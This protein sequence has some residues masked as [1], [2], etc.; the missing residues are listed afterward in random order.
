[1]LTSGRLEA[2]IAAE[3]ERAPTEP[4]LWW[5]GEWWSRGALYE[6]ANDCEAS[7]RESGFSSGDRL[8]L[9]LPNSPALLAAS[10][11]AWRLGGT[12]VPVSRNIRPAA[13]IELM[14]RAGVFGAIVSAQ[15][16][17]LL[18]S[19]R[20]AGI[21]CSPAALDDASPAIEGKWSVQPGS[22]DTAALFHTDAPGGAIAAV[23]ITHSNIM[24]LLSSIADSIPDLDEDDVM[25]NAIPNR[26]AFGL[27]V[28]GIFPLV[29][30]MPQV[31]VPSMAKPKASL[32]ASRIA[33]VTIMPVNPTMLRM[34][35]ASEDV[36]PLSK[37]RMLFC[38]GATDEETDRRA[39]A[40]FGVGP[41][42]GFGMPEASGLISFTLPDEEPDGSF[43]RI[44][45][46]IEHE[47]RDDS[48]SPMPPGSTGTLW[49]SGDAV[50]GG[51]FASPELTERRFRD[52]WFDTEISAMIDERGKLF[53]S[54]L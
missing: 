5:R 43:G 2:L 53:L 50:C 42:R 51:Y 12:I 3:A 37:V 46:C 41:L 22:S 23:P 33:D 31:L 26:H 35:L 19:L 10:I 45:P 25:L 11:A 52:G 48:L 13:L 15:R 1:M 4:C 29:S 20:L 9:V 47:I 40:E 6:M 14:R 16:A 21:P 30:G 32:M 38:G 7:L 39:R 34:M 49:I 36:P 17:S 44:L 24:T 27:I 8:A 18:D 28:G 54:D